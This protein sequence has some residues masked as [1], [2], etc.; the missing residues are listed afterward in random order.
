MPKPLYHSSSAQE[1]PASALVNDQWSRE[2]VPRLPQQVNEQAKRL[3]AFVRVREVKSAT[4]LLR[5]LLAY[6]L[7][8]SA[9]SFRR[10]GAWAMLIGLADMSETAWR[11]RLRKAS[12]WLLWR[13]GRTAGG[14][15]GGPDQSAARTHVG[16]GVTGGCHA[17]TRNGPAGPGVAGAHRL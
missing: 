7:C 11:Q 1:R 2:V 15:R 3:K 14:A 12:A 6:V 16:T 5:G 8:G 4:D 9:A 17:L 10:L 13:L